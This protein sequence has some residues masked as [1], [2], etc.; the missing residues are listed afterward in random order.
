MPNTLLTISFEVYK[1]LDALLIKSIRTKD[2]EQ[3]Q[4]FMMLGTHDRIL[5]MLSVNSRSLGWYWIVSKLAP[6]GD[7]TLKE[8]NTKLTYK[9]FQYCSIQFSLS[10]CACVDCCWKRVHSRKYNYRISSN[11]ICGYYENVPLCCAE[12]ISGRAKLSFI[13]RKPCAYPKIWKT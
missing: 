11:N 9:V 7:K 2:L 5:H 12:I 3:S 10:R 6:S 13:E 1:V 8:D 4:F